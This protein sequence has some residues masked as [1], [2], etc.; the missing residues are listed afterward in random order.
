MR[1]GFCHVSFRLASSPVSNICYASRQA[2]QPE[3][4]VFGYKC[5][6]QYGLAAFPGQW[7]EGECSARSAGS[8]CD[9]SILIFK[10][11]DENLYAC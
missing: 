6:Q 7:Q 5:K 8:G 1:S 9:I 3:T 2:C 10:C 11:A 4:S